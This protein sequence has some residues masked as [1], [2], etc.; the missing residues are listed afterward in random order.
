M[1]LMTKSRAERRACNER[2]RNRF[3]RII[4]DCW[5]RAPA[6]CLYFYDTRQRCRRPCC[7]HQRYYWGPCI[8]EIRA[9]GLTRHRRTGMSS[10]PAY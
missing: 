6:A 9:R 3:R 4:K 7:A 8:Q 5:G 1:S 10:G 2:A